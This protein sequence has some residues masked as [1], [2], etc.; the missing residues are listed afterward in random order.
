MVDKKVAS[1]KKV[2]KSKKEAKIVKKSPGPVSSVSRRTSSLRSHSVAGV[3]QEPSSLPPVDSPVKK[4]GSLSVP[5]YSLLGKEAGSLSLPKEVFGVKVNEALLSQALR[6]YMNNLKGHF[7]NTKS[8]GQVEGSSRKIY[9]QKGTGRARHGSIRANIFV[10]GGIALGPKVRKTV[11]DLPQKMKKAALVSALSQKVLDKGVIGL[12]GLEKATGKTQEM[13][14]LVARVKSQESS[15]RQPSVLIVVDK[16][17][18][19]AQRAVNNLQ[20][21]DFT[22]A[23]QLNAYEVIRHHSLIFTK[24]AVDKL[25]ARVKSQES[26]GVKNA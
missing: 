9:K 16:R 26:G 8:R 4:T 19:N 13:A 24:E 21:V 6:I 15:K 22:A 3:R 7:S 1:D 2:V 18:D 25:V 11:M 5:V 17:T 23:D 12:S 10:G 14:K 20:R